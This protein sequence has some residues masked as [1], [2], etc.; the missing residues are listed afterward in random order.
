MLPEQFFLSRSQHL[1]QREREK[2]KIMSQ[3]FRETESKVRRPESALFLLL[4][5]FNKKFLSK[6]LS[7]AYNAEL[8]RNAPIS[9]QIPK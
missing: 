6:T 8:N 3:M 5:N 4:N 7:D 9:M 2:K 1:A